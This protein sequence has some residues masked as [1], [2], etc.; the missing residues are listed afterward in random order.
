MHCRELLSQS[1]HIVD[2]RYMQALSTHLFDDT[3]GM[4]IPGEKDRENWRSSVNSAIPRISP[5]TANIAVHRGI[6]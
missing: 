2:A 1:Y 6:I 3:E 4:N 5:N